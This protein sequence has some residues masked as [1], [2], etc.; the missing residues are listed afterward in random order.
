MTEDTRLDPPSLEIAGTRATIRLH[1][2]RHRN[3][4]EP[5]DIIRIMEYL[6][7]VDAN[8]SLR[9]LV[10]AAN[11]PRTR[12][13]PPARRVLRPW[14]TALKPCACRPSVGCKAAFMVGPPILR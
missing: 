4:V 3:R 7:Q 13:R 2:S 12:K 6:E 14:W 9:V 5:G 1:R 8:P 10:L 11:G